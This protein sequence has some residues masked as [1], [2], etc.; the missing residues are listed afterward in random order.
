MEVVLGTRTDNLP[1]HG[2]RV[3]R[4]WR[5][6]RCSA[7]FH[8]NQLTKR[9]QCRGGEPRLGLSTQGYPGSNTRQVRATARQARRLARSSQSTGDSGSSEDQSADKSCKLARKGSMLSLMNE[10]VRRFAAATV[11]MSLLALVACDLWIRGFQLWWDRHSLTGSVATSLLVLAVTA[12]IVD[13]VVARRQRR[14]HAQSVAVQALIVYGQA[15]RAWKTVMT[16]GDTAEGS[17]SSPSEE[18]R[19]LASMLLTAAPGLFDDPVTRRFL[20]EVERFSGLVL[21][22]AVGSRGHL[23]DDDRAQLES[24]MTQLQAAVEPLFV[25]IPDADRTLLEGP[26]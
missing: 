1:W 24:A 26:P 19:T 20:E 8:C 5:G 13:E 6:E 23:S 21:R 9:S 25:R 4:R 12:L 15:R 7:T 17:A 16:V 2:H 11:T 14:E 10:A 3:R 18:L 22:I